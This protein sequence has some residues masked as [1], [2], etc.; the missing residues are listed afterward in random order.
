MGFK[1]SKSVIP[2]NK[3]CK[4]Q[5]RLTN[6]WEINSRIKV[7]SL[8]SLVARVNLN[9]IFSTFTSIRAANLSA[10]LKLDHVRSSPKFDYDL[11]RKDDT[12]Y[13]L[14]AFGNEANFK[15]SLNVSCSA[16]GEEAT[17]RITIDYTVGK[18][19][20]RINHIFEFTVSNVTLDHILKSQLFLLEYLKTDVW[21]KEIEGELPESNDKLSI[22]YIKPRQDKNR[23]KIGIGSEYGKSTYIGGLLRIKR[24]SGQY[25]ALDTGDVFDLFATKTGLTLDLC[26]VKPYPFNQTKI[27]YLKRNSRT[28]NYTLDTSYTIEFYNNLDLKPSTPSSIELEPCSDE[29]E[30]SSDELEPSSDELEPSSIEL[31]STTSSSIEPKP[32]TSS[33]I[34]PKPTTSS[35]ADL[36]YSYFVSGKLFCFTFLQF[37][38]PFYLKILIC[39]LVLL[40]AF[41]II[42]VIYTNCSSIIN[43]C[44]TIDEVSIKLYLLYG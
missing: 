35:S 38:K 31:G 22:I 23:F 10:Q 33:S 34:E 15:I 25:F 19:R 43:I 32:T 21:M 17:K 6:L 1:I 40:V 2:G 42:Y 28:L 16:F 44:K 12:I 11:F 37:L 3:S 8:E 5:I 18:P 7:N 39:Y 4:V 9:A 20:F 24:E 30:P 14:S 41:F 29:L 36:I 26:T 27:D 13:L